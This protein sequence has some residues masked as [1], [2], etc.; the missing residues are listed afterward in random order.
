[1]VFEDFMGLIVKEICLDVFTSS[2]ELLVLLDFVMNEVQNVVQIRED[3]DIAWF[4]A[5]VKEH[6]RRHPLVAHASSSCLEESSNVVSSG[7]ENYLSTVPSSKPMI[8][9]GDFQVI[10]DIHIPRDLK[11][12]DVFASKE[13]LS[14]C[15]YLIA[16]KK[17][18]E[19][20]TI[21]SNSRAIVFRCVQDGCQWQASSS[22]IA[23]CLR[24]DF[25]F[26]SSYTSTPS[27]IVNKVSSITDW[28]LSLI[29]SITD[30]MKIM[31]AIG[32]GLQPVIEVIG[33]FTAYEADINGHFKYC[34]MAIGALIEGWKHCRPNISV[35]GTFLKCKYARTLLTPSTI[36]GNNQIFSIA[37][38]IVDSENDASWRWFFENL[39]KSFGEREGLVIISD[40]HFNISKGV[41]NVFPNVE[42]CV[43]LR[44]LLQNMKLIYKDSLIDDIY[45]SCAK[46]YTIDKFEFYM[47]WME[48]IYPTIRE[49]LSK[50]GFEKWACAHSRRRRYNMMTTN[51]FECLNNILKEPR[52]FPVASLLDYIGE[53]LQNW[54]YE[55]S[56]SALFVKI[57]LTS[58]AESELREQHNQSRSFK[59]DPINNE[60]YKVV[61]EDKHFF[62]NLAYKS[63]S[64]HVWDLVEIPCV[65]ACAD[66]HAIVLAGHSL[67]HIEPL[68][69]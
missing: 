37:F 42:Y 55:K 6:N 14:N 38:S 2:I 47:K 26:S 24:N 67:E 49:Y 18:F 1:M 45:Y 60:E 68:C 39:K 43:C 40:R 57:V 4:L 48:S 31:E 19:F 56:Q 16:V 28:S 27:D 64:C 41:M 23:E 13:I 61:D 44:H 20:K 62:V 46:A 51:I 21:T 29:S 7:A 5:L 50:V 35:D 32:D 34:Y 65:H 17:N 9:D 52:E 66:H 33:T 58:W 69:P 8:D 30:N 59:V 25:R 63:Y 3:K 54:F 53:I 15:F 22:L 12:K 11:E 10:M 36:D